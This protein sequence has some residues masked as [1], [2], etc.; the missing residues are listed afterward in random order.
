MKENFHGSDVEK[1]EKRFGIKADEIVSFAANVSPLGVSDKYLEGITDKLHCV[2][3]YPERDYRRLR[4]A[5]SSYCDADPMH[6]MVGSGSSEII[7]AV[8]KH[9]MRPNVLI[10]SPAYS[11]Y[12]RNVTIAGGRA[13]YHALREED[14]FRFDAARLTDALAEEDDILMICNPVNP[15]GCAI[16][17]SELETVLNTCEK[18]HIICVVD[19]TYI[20]FADEKYDATSLTDKYPSLFVIRSMSKFFCAPGLRLGYAVSSDEALLDS[21]EENKDPWSVSS[22]SVEAAILMLSDKEYIIRARRYMEEER[23]RVCSMLDELREKGLSYIR[24]AANF[25]LVHL[26]DN[27]PSAEKLFNMAINEKMMIRN[28]AD[29]PGLE[30]GYIRFCFMKSEDDDR[31][32]SLIREA[33]A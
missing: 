22:L 9:I 12:E 29:Y 5:I 8:I 24:P 31:L 25:V 33:F 30:N 26:P 2:E 13:R 20:D 6:I 4:E 28:C 32:I 17:A 10:V 21:I 23:Q 11:E 16:E 15:T 27:G 14:G 19:E 7:S 3:R 18:L 1:I